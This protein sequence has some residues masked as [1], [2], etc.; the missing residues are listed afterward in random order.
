M[1]VDRYRIDSITVQDVVSL[2]QSIKDYYQYTA[3]TGALQRMADG[4]ILKSKSLLGVITALTALSHF[5]KG[6]YK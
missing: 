6:S 2:L 5:G 1:N 4:P 3:M